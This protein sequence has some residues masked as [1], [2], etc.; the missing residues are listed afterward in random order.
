MGIKFTA[1]ECDRIIDIS[2][3]SEKKLGQN[4]GYNTKHSYSYTNLGYSE[5][6]SWIFDRLGIFFTESSGRKLISPLHQISIHSYKKGEYFD[7][8]SDQNYAMYSV[9]A[10]LND[11]YE[12]GDFIM[13]SPDYIIPKEKGLI[14]YF[15]SRKQ[16]KIT[17]INRGIRWSLISFILKGNLEI[18][19][20]NN[21]I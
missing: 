8:H 4:L 15:D 21:L 2:N 5:S 6:T 16:H 17:K 9:G 1:E 19:N 18:S 3:R 10:C 13:Y 14:Y 20:K 7:R 11:D 12:G